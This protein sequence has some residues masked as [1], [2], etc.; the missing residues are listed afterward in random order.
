MGK[1]ADNLRLTSKWKLS[2]IIFLTFMLLNGCGFKD[3]DK[4]FFVVSIGVDLAKNSSK[5]YLVSL[6]FAVPKTTRESPAEYQIVSEE[7]NS[8]SEAVRIIKT[9]VDKEIDFS[10]ANVILLGDELVKRRGN[11]GVNYWFIR[12]RD[13]Q[14]IAWIAV[15][16]PSALAVLKVKPTSEYFPSNALFLALGKDGSETPYVISEFL[17]DFKFRAIE[18]GIDPV[19]PIIEA[20]KDILEINTVG[21]FNKSRMLLELQPEETKMLNFF[22]NREEKSSLWGKKGQTNMIVNTE[23][24]KS[25]YKIY[26]PKGKKPYI[27]FDVSVDAVLEETTKRIANKQLSKYEKVIGK[28]FSKEALRVLRKIQKAGLDPVGFGLRYRSRH[29]NDNDW[30]EWQRIYPTIDFKVH[31][32]VQ[33][34]DTGLIE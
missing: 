12:R 4:R 27:Q 19:L 15:G 25:K 20:K 31:T 9:K 2:F 1:E 18:R 8:I 11:A 7:A 30:K 17:Y 13:V 34:S 3:I 32:K 26:T 29:F 22:L 10:H 16:K 21:L 6:K 28:Q 24:V 14:S 5:K 23:K 33:I